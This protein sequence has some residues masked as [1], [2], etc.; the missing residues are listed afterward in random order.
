MNLFQYLLNAN[1]VLA[2]KRTFP[3]ILFEKN[4]DTTTLHQF[5]IL[6]VLYVD[7]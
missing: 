4:V 1:A 2:L 5:E 6:Y 3:I 7:G